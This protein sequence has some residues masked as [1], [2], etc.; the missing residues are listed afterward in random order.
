M[1]PCITQIYTSKLYI[2][3]QHKT[4]VVALIWVYLGG[5]LRSGCAQFPFQTEM[6]TKFFFKSVKFGVKLIIDAISSK[7][8]N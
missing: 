4:S 7:F 2:N 5:L 1:S 6:T 8:K 3:Q